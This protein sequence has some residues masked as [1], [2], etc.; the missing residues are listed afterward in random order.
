M[1][2]L[3]GIAAATG[4]SIA[5]AYK[6]GKEEIVVSRQEITE[7][8]PVF[9]GLILG[10][11][12]APRRI[13][14]VAV[15]RT[16]RIVLEQWRRRS[17][18]PRDS[19]GPCWPWCVGRR[20]RFRASRR[21]PRAVFPSG[22]QSFTLDYATELSRSGGVGARQRG[23][24]TKSAS[25]IDGRTDRGGRIGRIETRPALGSPDVRDINEPQIE[26]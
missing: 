19:E 13:C 4:I 24:R 22:V 9:A 3:K 25:T 21:K 8:P 23:R 26:A 20:S 14:L 1:I 18:R 15:V 5:P 12:S 10:A 6:L 11:V 16:D 17:A 2:E 7:P